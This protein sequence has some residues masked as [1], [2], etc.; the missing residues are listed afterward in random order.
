MGRELSVSVA[1]Q[2]FMVA[3]APLRH[4]SRLRL[5]RRRLFDSAALRECSIVN[6][7]C[8]LRESHS[9]WGIVVLTKISKFAIHIANLEHL[10]LFIANCFI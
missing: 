1:C 8:V 10:G 9:I 4:V 6:G 5:A 2:D 3:L 7:D